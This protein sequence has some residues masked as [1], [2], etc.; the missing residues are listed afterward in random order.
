MNSTVMDNCVIEDNCI[1]AAGAVV[2]EGTK[3][4]SGSI[5]AGVPA[6]MVKKLTPEL[7]ENEVNRIANNYS[8]YASWFE[9]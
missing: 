8:M 4:N 2:L 3:I 5:Y 6:K 1:I 9:E 7:F